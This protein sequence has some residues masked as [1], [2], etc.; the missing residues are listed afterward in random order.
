MLKIFG[1]DK[2]VAE[3]MINVFG[4][5]IFKHIEDDCNDTYAVPLN[6]NVILKCHGFDSSVKIELGAKMFI[7]EKKNYWRIVIE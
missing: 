7:L 6:D 4:N 3:A 5:R 1:L 2:E